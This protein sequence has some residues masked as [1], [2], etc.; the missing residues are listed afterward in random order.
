V[1]QYYIYLHYKP[2]E[3]LFYIGKGSGKRAYDFTTSRSDWYKSIVRKYGRENITVDVLNCADEAD[4]IYQEQVFI[5]MAK[6]QGF[7]LCNLTDGGDGLL[8][9][10]QKTREKMA[11]SARGNTSRRGKRASQETLEKMRIASLGNKNA[12]GYKHSPEVIARLKAS[13]RGRTVWNKGLKTGP[14]SVEH[15]EK[16][17][18]SS[19]GKHYGN[20]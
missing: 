18:L 19:L 16:I 1:K 17:R 14:H 11:K 2:D 15:N 9:P 12:L 10:S 13:L 7:E 8:N 4:S 3:I 5:L 20:R 6:E